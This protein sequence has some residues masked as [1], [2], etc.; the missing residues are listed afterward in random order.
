[1]GFGVP[2]P[3]TDFTE[4][5]SKRRKKK[6]KVERYFSFIDILVIFT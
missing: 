2:P 1:M 3:D 6:T 5:Q 4:F